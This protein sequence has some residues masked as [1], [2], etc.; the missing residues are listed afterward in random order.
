M[1]PAALRELDQAAKPSRPRNDTPAAQLILGSGLDSQIALHSHAWLDQAADDAAVRQ[2]WSRQRLYL[3]P[4]F[5]QIVDETFPL[6]NT[7][8]AIEGW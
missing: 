1:A 2:W 4:D 5:G 3:N 8:A 6:G 7:S